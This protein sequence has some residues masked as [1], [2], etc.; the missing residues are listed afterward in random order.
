MASSDRPRQR[1]PPSEPRDGQP[2][3]VLVADD[4]RIARE[5]LVSV[6]RGAGHLV[7]AVA[8]GQEA[9]DRAAQGG[10]DL[11]LLD[12][13]MPRMS[14]IEACRIL[15]GLASDAFLPVI[16]VT[17]RTDP[18]SRVDG[19]KIG[20]DDYVAKPF[21]ELELVARVEA[22]LR[23]KRLHDHVTSE[24]DRL[25]RLSVRD[26]LTGLYNYRYLNTRL[27][28]E[29]KRA[30]QHY[31]PFACLLIDIDQLRVLNETGGRRAGDLAIVAVAQAI[32]R[33]VSELDV[34]ARY[35]GEE[36]LVILPGTHF[37]GATSRAERIWRDVGALRVEL[38]GRVH[39]LTVSVGVALYPARDVR[40]RDAL[41]RAA[42]SALQQAKREGG[43][44]LSVHQ[45]HG[46]APPRAVGVDALAPTSPRTA[47]ELVEL[48]RKS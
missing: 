1:M 28:E 39:A 15:K 23:M 18:A 29:H 27:A 3:R 40:T 37:A 6:L 30:E 21:D 43:N 22:V 46:Q 13:V 42:E 17:V 47:A 19:L 34:I 4:D 12:V 16:L 38:E 14:G 26:E 2:A 20:A 7:E 36:F 10:F 8:D 45:Q 32:Q 44:R 5:L 41:L 25:A 9:V 35:G 11:V 31:E 33:A 24:R 48:A